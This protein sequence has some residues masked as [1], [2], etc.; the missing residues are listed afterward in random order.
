[1]A[2]I[3]GLLLG[4][5]ACTTTRL[6]YE[7]TPDP[8]VAYEHNL[9][10][11]AVFRASHASVQ[12]PNY[13]PFM[14][15]RIGV[16]EGRE[17]LVLCHWRAEDFPLAVHLEAPRIDPALGDEF[18]LREPDEYV[19]AVQRAM[20][21]W[22]HDLGEHISFREV[23][24]PN[25]ARLTIRLLGEQA[26]VAE[27][28]MQVLGLAHSP[29]GACHFE[30][31]DPATGRVEVHFSIPE[32]R[33]YVADQHGLLLP[34]QV[35]KVALHELGHALGMR[36]HS[37]IP[38][39]LMYEVARDRIAR[40]GLGLAD[41]NS[42]QTLYT[43]PS[44]TIYADLNSAPRASQL[45]PPRGEPRLELA[46]H[47]DPRLG[48][49]LQTPEGWVSI[50]TRFGLV[51][52]DGVAWDYRASFQLNVARFETVEAYLARFGRAHLGQSTML[53]DG[54]LVVA[55]RRARRFVLHT[56]R[57]TLEEL[58]LLATGDGRVLVAIGEG[59]AEEFET[60]RNWFD[61]ILFSL[62]LREDG[63]PAPSRS[64]GPG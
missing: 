17:R 32:L 30:G 25:D 59:P 22:Q 9:P 58:T 11:Y 3:L 15:Y 50:P 47:V 38:A 27:Q 36:G 37:P 40:G 29:G 39:D 55:G 4:W 23:Q 21:F 57:E 52:I 28:D 49:E 46:P 8:R 56:P 19:K 16:G 35:E 54:E 42:F 63:R 41:S 10:D 1:M 5:S 2:P 24:D 6:A 20:A 44:G 51:T 61:K 45:G 31:G 7:E 43:L 60:Y 14:A 64:Y 33:L 34:S 48:F 26:P 53:E 12:D 18:R 62:E 13:L